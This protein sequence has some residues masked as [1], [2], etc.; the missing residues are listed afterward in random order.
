MS[1]V[2]LLSQ[3]KSIYDFRVGTENYKLLV[4]AQKDW[5]DTQSTMRE[6]RKADRNRG[7]SLVGLQNQISTIGKSADKAAK[8]CSQK[9]FAKDQKIDNLQLSYGRARGGLKDVRTMHKN[10]AGACPICGIDHCPTWTLVDGL[11]SGDPDN[12]GNGGVGA[13]G[14]GVQI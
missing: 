11:L 13:Q 8:D 1:V 10:V 4:A 14:H 2:I 6:L 12:P 3:L 7:Q 5:D 9:I